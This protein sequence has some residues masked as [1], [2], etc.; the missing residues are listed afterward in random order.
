M[1]T[2]IL[3]IDEAGRGCVI[4]PM[5]LCGVVMKKHFEPE[6]KK[7]GVKDSKELTPKKRTNLIS[8]MKNLVDEVIIIEVSPEK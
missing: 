5:V 3:G 6:L 4:G 8:V 7:I 2:K 1:D